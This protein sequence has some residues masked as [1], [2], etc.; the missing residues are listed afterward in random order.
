MK[1]NKSQEQQEAP[2]YLFRQMP[3]GTVE[4]GRVMPG[5]VI[6]T[7][8][9]Q[10]YEVAMDD[11]RGVW[12]DPIKT[13]EPPKVIYGDALSDVNRYFRTFDRLGTNMGVMFLGTK[14]SGKTV[15]IRT[16]I[17]TAL[18]MDMPVICVNRALP[19]QA[20]EM[21]IRAVNKESLW[22]FEEFDKTFTFQRQDGEDDMSYQNV[23]L[24][25]L[26]GTVAG[27]ARKLYVL[28][29]NRQELISD[30]LKHRPGRI[31]YTKKFEQ[32]PH[33]VLV[34]YVKA[35]L[36]SNNPMDVV[37]FVKMRTVYGP[38]NFDIMETVVDELN[39]NKDL[40]VVSALDL[41]FGDVQFGPRVNYLCQV[42]FPDGQTHVVPSYEEIYTENGAR[43]TIDLDSLNE[44]EEDI[45][46]NTWLSDKNFVSASEDY[47]TFFYEKDG[48]K[49]KLWFS[50]TETG[51]KV[52]PTFGDEISEDEFGDNVHYRQYQERRRRRHIALEEKKRREK[53][54]AAADAEARGEKP[55][56]EQGGLPWQGGFRGGARNTLDSTQSHERGL[57]EVGSG[58]YPAGEQPRF[59]ILGRAEPQ[60]HALNF[61]NPAASGISSIPGDVSIGKDY[62]LVNGAARPLSDNEAAGS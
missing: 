19:P 59:L 5:N 25:I 14:G 56:P 33:D 23:L 60:T 35:N 38:M 36:K 22:V 3:D 9:T 27:G 21:L 37:H 28:A 47:T 24:S 53:N 31:R 30:Y 11:E 41:L 13:P 18:G 50:R 1:S 44:S 54:Q 51:K 55:E 15:R 42:T 49:F 40:N 39:H 46:V 48:Y 8:P 62:Y 57:G 10:V 52:I 34:D 12:L 58:A 26:D 7:L 16:M 17:R 4:P 2:K 6:P 61:A 29:A 20:L 32:L 45:H 43:I